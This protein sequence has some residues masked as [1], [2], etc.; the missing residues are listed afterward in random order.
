VKLTENAIAR[1]SSKETLKTP[2]AILFDD[3]L[4]GFGLRIRA[5][6]SKTWVFQ[7]KLGSQHRRITLGK[8]PALHPSQARKTASNLHAEV[9]LGNDP[10]A[11]KAAK[12]VR[13]AETFGAVLKIYLARRRGQ[14]RDSSLA[15][16]ERHLQRNFAPLHSAPVDKLDRR[17]I[18][19][20]LARLTNEAGPIQAN[21]SRASLSKFLNWCLAESLTE[22]NAAMHT[23]KNVE[24]SRDRVLNNKELNAI[25]NA[26]HE[27]SDYSAIVRLLILTGQRASEIAD[28]RWSEI[29]LE[30]NIIVLPSSRTKNHR[31]HIVPITS[32]VRAILEA[33]PRRD[34][35]DF[36]FGVGER[37]FSGWSKSKARLDDAV[38]IAPF[39][40]HDIRR[41]VATGMSEIGIAPFHV[42]AVLNHISGTSSVARIYN[43]NTFE[44]EKG[45]ALNRWA[46]NVAAIVEGRDSSVTPLL[47]GAS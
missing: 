24:K 47:R 27:D 3:D 41:S 9:R 34:G 36:V 37:G 31:V 15:E 8:F 6:G 46:E 13:A 25:W 39:V 45:T 14:V 10:A 11:V 22:T 42:E 32:M 17:A 20:Q 7:Y 33:R 40:I 16:M 12:Q 4:P 23:N 43:K 19:A 1:L 18:A 29:D 44:S 5:G 35:R 21:R 26:L 38:N 30:R 2:D 28:L